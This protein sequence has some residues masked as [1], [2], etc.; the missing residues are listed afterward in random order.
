MRDVVQLVQSKIENML[1]SPGIVVVP[2]HVAACFHLETKY[3]KL[4]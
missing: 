3:E 2:W 4:S 1:R